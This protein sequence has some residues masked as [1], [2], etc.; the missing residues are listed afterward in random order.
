MTT[1]EYLFGLVGA[2]SLLK[3]DETLSKLV[4]V[5]SECYDIGDIAIKELHK[6]QA[7]VVDGRVR[8]KLES[9]SKTIRGFQLGDTILKLNGLHAQLETYA[10]SLGAPTSETVRPLLHLLRDVISA[11]EVFIMNPSLV[12]VH[13]CMISVRELDVSTP[14]LSK[15]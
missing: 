11:Y 5:S 13:N 15:F 9:L 4:T 3:N 6:Y 8:E 10:S 2:H 14:M 12:T 1:Y 7:H